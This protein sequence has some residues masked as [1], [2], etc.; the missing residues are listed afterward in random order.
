MTSGGIEVIQFAKFCLISEA[1]FEAIPYLAVPYSSD[2]SLLITEKVIS[3]QFDEKLS[4]KSYLSVLLL[5][6]C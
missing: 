1:K 5:P 4:M 2:V 6:I 3:V